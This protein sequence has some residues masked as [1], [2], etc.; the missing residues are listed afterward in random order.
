VER[1]VRA[2]TAV[3]ELIRSGRPLDQAP[4]HRLLSLAGSDLSA[5]EIEN[6]VCTLQPAVR[7]CDWPAYLVREGLSLDGLNRHPLDSLEGVDAG[8]PSV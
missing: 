2:A 4:C 7:G 8:N 3:A 1:V 5:A 6:V